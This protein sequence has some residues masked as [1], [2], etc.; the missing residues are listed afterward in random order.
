MT[1]LVGMVADDLTGA[2]DATAPF[3][4]RGL[5]TIVVVSPD[6]AEFIGA[7][8]LAD[9][10][11]ICINTASRE[12]DAAEAERRVREAT[13]GLLGL[14]PQVLFKKIDSRLKGHLAVEIA[15]M[16]AASGRSLPVVAPAIPDLGRRVVDGRLVG[17]GVPEPLNIAERL[18]PLVADVP[19]TPDQAALEA[20]AEWIVAD[21]AV[22]IAVGARGLSQAIANLLPFRTVRRRSGVLPCPCVVAIGSRDPVTRAQIERLGGTKHVRAPNGAL[23][24]LE[25]SPDVTLVTAEQGQGVEDGKIVAGRFAD[26]LARAIAAS[27]PASLLISGGET[28]YAVLTRLGVSSITVEGEALP[29]VPFATTLIGGRQVVI[30]TKSGGFGAP[31]TISL[32]V[33][34]PA[35]LH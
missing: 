11:V 19:E 8:E 9:A 13:K 33:R 3:A 7:G 5:R 2:L 29:G 25:F 35:E 17:A 34:Q 16:V 28:A 4:E 15:A 6:G 18:G 26:G 30:L 14:A 10:E 20:V 1:L 27:P 12:I 32:L 22:C 24:G 21:G 23:D 31:D